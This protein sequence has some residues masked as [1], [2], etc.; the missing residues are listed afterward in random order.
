MRVFQRPGCFLVLAL[1]YIN[2]IRRSQLSLLETM[3]DCIL[4]RYMHCGACEW[5]KLYGERV[6]KT[7]GSSA[8][9]KRMPLLYNIARKYRSKVPILIELEIYSSGV[10]VCD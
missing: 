6:I 8:V 7:V 4:L 2:V 5:I 9:S 3:V 10:L 1:I